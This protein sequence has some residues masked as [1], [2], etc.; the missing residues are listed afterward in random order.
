M[1]KA[2]ICALL[3]CLCISNG[4]TKKYS[5]PN[6]TSGG[7][8]EKVYDITMKQDILCLMMAYPGYIKDVKKTDDGVYIVM[9][10]GNH[11]LYDDKKEKNFNE[12]LNNA[13]LQDMMEQVYP[14]YDI[15]DL[16][17][18][19][20]DPGRI[21]VY[22]LLKEVYGGSK[23]VVQSNLT[24]VK[25]GGRYYQ[26]NEKNKALE[27]LNNVMR[28][29]LPLLKQRKDLYP[30]VFPISGTFSYRYIANTK[31]LSS[32]SFGIAIDLAR[33]KRDYWM[34]V[35]REEGQKRLDM[36]PRDIVKIFE[37]YNFIWGGKWAHFDILHYEYRPEIILKAR[38]FSYSPGTGKKW[39]E[40]PH[41]EY[42]AVKDYI[43]IIERALN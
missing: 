8:N 18:D 9:N 14:L 10:S 23:S 35:S 20:N 39:Y 25:V 27:A 15:K 1:K 28:E 31:L 3:L 33:D 40:G 17:T 12:K 5:V 30:F 34:W 32:H 37:K 19:N 36:Y 11:I 4:C 21:R 41:L 7:F 2:F 42:Y 13:D 16:M 29:I 38:Y 22:S 26:F 24:N 6:M 43:E